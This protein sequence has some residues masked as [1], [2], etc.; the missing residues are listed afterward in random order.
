MNTL[1]KIMLLILGWKT[2]GSFPNL[3]KSIVIFAPHTSYWDSLYGKLFFMQSAVNHKFITKSEYFKFP[4]NI[5][6][7]LY[8]SIPVSHNRKYVAEIAQLIKSQNDIHIVISP[9]GK[10]AKTIRWKKGFYYMATSANVPIVVGYIDY[11][12]KE[13]G[14]KG[15]VNNMNNLDSTFS[16]INK[17]YKDVVAKHPEEFVLDTRYSA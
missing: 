6:L 5:L 9:E 2:K 14:I 4:Q 15:V 11:K 17:M 7:N 16:Q 1:A 13:V 8:G 3:P 10:L 12:K